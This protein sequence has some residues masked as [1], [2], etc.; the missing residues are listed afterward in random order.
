MRRLR[1]FLREIDCCRLKKESQD[2]IK[3]SCRRASADARSIDPRNEEPFASAT[4]AN[5]EDRD[6]VSL[7]LYPAR[8]RMPGDAAGNNI[9]VATIIQS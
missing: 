9:A 5:V 6:K 1:L 3:C 2:A 8:R 4:A 7:R